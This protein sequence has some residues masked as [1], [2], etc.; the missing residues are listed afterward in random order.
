MALADTPSFIGRRHKSQNLSLVKCTGALDS[1]LWQLWG[2]PPTW[3]REESRAD[4][5][6]AH[7][8]VRRALFYTSL[9]WLRV[10]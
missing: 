7:I 3:A 1:Q 2:A 6:L 4:S 10:Q 9:M 5:P 8:L